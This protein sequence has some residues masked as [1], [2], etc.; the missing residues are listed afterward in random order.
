MTR[1]AY[2]EYWNLKEVTDAEGNTTSYTY[3][4]FN[5]VESITDARGYVTRN[6]YDAVTG[7]LIIELRI[8][9]EELLFRGVFIVYLSC[10]KKEERIVNACKIL[11]HF[12]QPIVY[13][14]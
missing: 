8:K 11:C 10:L 4:A 14:V 3:N 5:A 9:N 12:S 13:S 6:E 2:D 7:D 1:Y